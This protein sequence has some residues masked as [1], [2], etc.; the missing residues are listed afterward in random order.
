[1]INHVS[2][3][4]RDLGKA[5]R[6]YDTALAPLGYKRLFDSA[7]AL[8][9]GADSPKLWVMRAER[10]VTAHEASGTAFVLRR[11]E[12]RRCR[13]LPCGSGQIGRAR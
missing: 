4:A 3:G 2:I 8:G 11:G 1:M 10:P 6:F 12:S 7:E 5:G 13:P 9:Y